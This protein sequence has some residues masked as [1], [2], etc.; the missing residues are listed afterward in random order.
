MPTSRDFNRR[1]LLKTSALT[2][3]AFGLSPFLGRLACGADTGA[4]KKIL[5]FTKSSGFQHSVI[6]RS[7][8][9]PNKLAYSE[10]ILTDLGA[11]HGFEV[12]CSKDGNLFKSGEFEK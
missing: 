8:D 3:A 2:A 1:D 7:A 4:P 10:Q 11:K 5:Y 9:D 6:T 12:T